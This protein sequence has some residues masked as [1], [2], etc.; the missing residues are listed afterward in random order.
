M[1]AE[2]PDVQDLVYVLD[3]SPDG[4]FEPSLI[5]PG[6]GNGD[7]CWWTYQL[8]NVKPQKAK[9][10]VEGTVKI[11]NVL[12]SDQGFFLRH[13]ELANAIRR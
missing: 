3:V 2:L 9:V 6:R 13:K 10:R 5:V 12:S 8:T 1:S 7:D 4:V 11:L